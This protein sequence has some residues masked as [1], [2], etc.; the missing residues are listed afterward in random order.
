GMGH[1]GILLALRKSPERS[2]V[3]NDTLQFVRQCRVP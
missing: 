1:L 3:L 2:Q